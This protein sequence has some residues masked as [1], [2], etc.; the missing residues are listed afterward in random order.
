M[1]SSDLQR[2]YA[3]LLYQYFGELRSRTFTTH[4]DAA[5]YLLDRIISISESP[6]HRTN[7]ICH[8]VLYVFDRDEAFTDVYATSKGLQRHH[9]T[10]RR[11]IVEPLQRKI[12]RGELSREQ[13][14]S[15]VLDWVRRQQTTCLV[16]ISEANDE[17]QPVVLQRSPDG[18]VRVD[19][20]DISGGHLL[21]STFAAL[22]NIIAGHSLAPIAP[23]FLLLPVAHAIPEEEPRVTGLFFGFLSRESDPGR[24][25]ML[26][27]VE[28]E[29]DQIERVLLS[30]SI[31]GT[32]YERVQQKQRAD[33]LQ[34]VKDLT[35]IYVHSFGRFAGDLFRVAEFLEAATTAV[36]ITEHLAEVREIATNLNSMKEDLLEPLTELQWETRQVDATGVLDKVLLSFESTFSELAIGLDRSDN[37]S[38]SASADIDGKL[39]QLILVNMIDNAVRAVSTV[40]HQRVIKVTEQVD[41]ESRKL[42]I[43]VSDNGCGLPADYESKVL[44][45][46]NFSAWDGKR[47]TGTGLFTSNAM[48][49]M[50]GGTLSIGP[51]SD[52]DMATTVSIVLRQHGPW[53]RSTS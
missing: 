28:E 34:G 41:T 15:G 52:A 29:L 32:D 14:E 18:F 53:Q 3:T 36:D 19:K 5:G 22:T 44:K 7:H 1:S 39:L 50:F 8:A 35:N 37:H 6:R 4:R 51:A 40:A 26:S 21:N 49:K 47:G 27:V 10:I 38:G 46:R 23:T 12:E 24:D 48:L 42:T 31:L 43:S 17:A 16:T 20:D 11:K 30:I 13:L 45:T 33:V 2:K 25:G 9:E